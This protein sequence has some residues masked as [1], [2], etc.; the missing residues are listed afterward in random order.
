MKCTDSRINLKHLLSNVGVSKNILFAIVLFAI[1]LIG[2][3]A[4]SILSLMIINVYCW[5]GTLGCFIAYKSLMWLSMKY[6]GDLLVNIRYL[7]EFSLNILSFLIDIINPFLTIVGTYLFVTLFAF[8]IPSIILEC[9]NILGV[10]V[11]KPETIIFLVFVSGSI[12]CSTSYKTSKWIIRHSPLRNWG[13]HHYESYREELAI[14]LI[15]PKNITFLLY[16][17]YFSLLG[18]SSFLQLETSSYLF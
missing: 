8:G 9:L 4:F 6:N 12:L 7:I 17:I 3:I 10:L 15:H 11:L 13:E 1:I 5:I 2:G 18:I 16:L 14:Y